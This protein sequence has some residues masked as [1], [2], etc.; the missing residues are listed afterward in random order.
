M[1][2]QLTRRCVIRETDS[3][4]SIAIALLIL[5]VSFPVNQVTAQL[6]MARLNSVFPPGLQAGEKTIVE[7]LGTDLDEADRMHFSDPRITATRFQEPESAEKE[8]EEKPK[9]KTIRFE[10]TAAKDVPAGLYEARAS[11]VYGVTNARAFMI[12]GFPESVEQSP[13]HSADNAQDI[14]IGTV[15][16]GHADKEAIDHYRLRARQGQRILIQFWAE[17]IDSQLDAT[18][19][20]RDSDGKEL[21]RNRDTHGSDPFIDY[22]APTDQEI[23]LQ[24]FDFLYRGGAD[25]FYRLQA[26]TG[27]YLDFARPLALSPGKAETV[28]LFGRN[29]PDGR[30]ADLKASDG[31]TLETIDVKFEASPLSETT[32]PVPWNERAGPASSW[33]DAALYRLPAGSSVSNPVFISLF[34]DPIVMEAE[35]NNTVGQ[36]QAVMPPLIIEGA[37]ETH[38]DE[39]RYRFE[40]KPDQA[41]RI[42]VLSH[43]LGFL[44]D[45]YLK[46]SLHPESEAPKDMKLPTIPD[47]LSQNIGGRKFNLTSRDTSFRFQATHIGPYVL[48]VRDNLVGAN[49]KTARRYLLMIRP[50]QPDYDLLVVSE[51]LKEK[52]KQETLWPV[53][54]RRGGS[55]ALKVLVLRRD[56]FSEPIELSVTG[57]PEDVKANASIIPATQSTGWVIL[58]AQE[59]AAGWVGEI[60]LMGRAKSKN[61]ELRRQARSMEL[62]RNVSDY[63]Q[64]EVVSRLTRNMMLAVSGK[65]HA[66]FRTDCGKP[67][68]RSWEGTVGE[69]VEI[70][71]QITRW[72]KSKGDLTL[73]AVGLPGLKKAPTV[74]VSADATE[75]KLVLDLKNEEKNRIPP[76]DHWFHLMGEGKFEYI[77]G[78]HAGKDDKAKPSDVNWQQYSHPLH[79]KVL[80]QKE[81]K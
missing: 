71:I 64:A 8:G 11:G 16:Y 66:P 67:E 77:R 79:I 24:V 10:V 18:L 61:G 57:L 47:D 69:K 46:L 40:A 4:G 72:L 68:Q 43:R 9:A 26:A 7:I 44:T 53:F 33:I 29:L 42:E 63:N 27:P 51:P 54:V 52:D 62:V 74:K 23:I 35:P 48:T 20:L 1:Q 80:P 6:P 58:E 55:L 76:G 36:A 21:A 65:E 34:T 49:S 25:Y 30:Q 39:D 17:H 31:T 81:S 28:T 5:G 19:V 41:Y 38:T 60:A 13:N 59:D 15:M 78:S 75:A 22:T 50:E 37:F 73:T 70:P 3:G 2:D 12:G 45:P 14:E 56:G 32:L